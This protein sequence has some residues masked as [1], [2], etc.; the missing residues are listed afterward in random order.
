MSRHRFHSICPYFAMFPES[1]AARWIEEVTQPGDLVLDPFCGRGTAPFQALLMGRRAVG[2][3]TNPV[4]ACVTRAKTDAP[5]RSSVKRRLTALEREFDAGEWE[6]ERKRLPE[7]F[8]HA[9]RPATLRQILFLRDRLDWRRRKSDCMIST[10]ALGALHGESKVSPSYLSNQMPRT[11]STKPAYSV[12]YWKKHGFQP[13]QRDAFNLLRTALE[14]R[15]RDD[16]PRGEATI[17]HG[18]MR[19]LP[20]QLHNLPGPVSCVITSPPYLDL[21]NFEEDQWLRLWFLNGPPYP[22][23]GRFSRDDR[24]SSPNTYWPLITDMW[25]SIGAVVGPDA[26]VIV[27]IGVKGLPPERVRDAVLGASKVCSRSVDLEG[28]EVSDLQKRQTRSFRPGAAG[29]RVEVDCH[30]KV[31]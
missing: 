16:P 31:A 28:Y 15:Y 1:F 25:R 24:H 29:C 7:F 4:A 30:F 27:R 21:T 20:S 2:V 14:F 9:Y 5:P 8:R 23:S 26:S 19:D 17:I 11:I 12:R 18:D 6:A 3:D 10:L 22:S 13:P